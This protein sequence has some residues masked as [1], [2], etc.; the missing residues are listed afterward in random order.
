[1][2]DYLDKY[3]PHVLSETAQYD[4]ADGSQRLRIIRW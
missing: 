4:A 1:M 2:P 3:L